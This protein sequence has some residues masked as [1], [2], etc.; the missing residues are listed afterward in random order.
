MPISREQIRAS[1]ERRKRADDIL[2]QVK[3]GVTLFLRTPD[4]LV[5]I[6]RSSVG[7]AYQMGRKTASGEI[8]T[9]RANTYEALAH[10]SNALED[11]VEPEF[12]KE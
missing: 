8:K 9:F 11:G 12:K 6:T 4:G 10:I 1:N 5:T 3:K 7:R 2:K